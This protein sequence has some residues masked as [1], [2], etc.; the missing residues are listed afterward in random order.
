MAQLESLVVDDV[1]LHRPSLKLIMSYEFQ[2]RKEAVE[3][4]NKGDTWVAA[5]KSVVKNAD[6]R[7]RYFST[8]LPVTSALQSIK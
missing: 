7:E 2:M 6:I 5:L 8:P 1:A 3:Q 4:V